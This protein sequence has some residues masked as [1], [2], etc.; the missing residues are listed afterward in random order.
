MNP[1]RKL[2]RWWRAPQPLPFDHWYPPH[3]TIQ[4]WEAGPERCFYCLAHVTSEAADQPCP[5]RRPDMR[6]LA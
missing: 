6:E 4:C 1:L 2:W 5:R 3:S